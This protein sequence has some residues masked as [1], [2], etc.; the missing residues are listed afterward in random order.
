MGAVAML[1]A[2]PHHFIDRTLREGPFIMMPTDLHQ[3]NLLVDEQW[4]IT[5]LIDLEWICA[6]PAQMC[7]EPHW[8]TGRG[9]DE[10]TGEH[11]DEYN[12]VRTEFL[13][14][15]EEVEAEYR[16][17]EPSLFS[18]AKMMETGWQTGSFWYFVSIM[19]VDAAYNVFHQHVYKTYTSAPRTTKMYEHF[20]R[21][22]CPQ[23]ER[24]TETKL[25][26][27]ET[28]NKQLKALFNEEHV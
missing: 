3:S 16:E 17:K 7:V 11:L 14:I 26:D 21:F 8:L 18:L 19:T 23:S 6:L 24:I 27:R 1:R 12:A 22:W 13:R 2:V 4:N 15:L 20:S 10:I 9:V 28:Y 25:V 5:Y